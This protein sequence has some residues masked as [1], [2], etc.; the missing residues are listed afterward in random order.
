MLGVM[1]SRRTEQPIL[2]LWLTL[3]GWQIEIERDGDNFVGVARHLTAD[4]S[5]VRVGGCA[6]TREELAY[7]LFEAAMKIIE[8][9]GQKPRLLAA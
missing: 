6:R 5:S 1:D 8:A 4:G 7:Q 2:L 3:L 9:C